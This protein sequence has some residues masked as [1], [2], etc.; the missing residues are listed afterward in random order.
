MRSIWLLALF[1]LRAYA[2]DTALS[3]SALH[4]EG[5]SKNNQAD[6]AISVA[7]EKSYY[8]IPTL[9]RICGPTNNALR[10]ISGLCHLL[11]FYNLGPTDIPQFNSGQTALRV[12]TDESTA[13]KIL[14]ASPFI[15]TRK[16]IRYV[17]AKD[18][19]FATGVGES[20]RDQCLATFA[21]LHLPLTTPL[22]LKAGNYSIA[23]LLSDS[24]AS[25]SFDEREPAWTGFALAKYL[26]PVR[27]WSNR[28]G[29][30]ASFSSL[31][32][33]LIDL[34]WN[35]QSCAGTHVFQALLAIQQ[36]DDAFGILDMSVRANLRGFIDNLLKEAKY[37]QEEDGGWP[38]SWCNK[39]HRNKGL[40]DSFE[41]RVIV[42]GHLLEVLD[43][44]P[45]AKR[46]PRNVYIK[47]A[48]ALL[49]ALNS[50][51]TNL[52]DSIICPFTHAARVARKILT[53]SQR[54][55]N[56]FP[57]H[58]VNEAGAESSIKH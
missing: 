22:T 37:S 41:Q 29:E 24:I 38:T 25:F 4:V 28:F 43:S 56:G 10:S 46:L 19:V 44:V 9:K 27:S 17:L 30:R 6:P 40:G 1:A 49:P 53:D 23:D 11:L 32:Q 45:A 15:R 47:G 55:I 12:L 18:P 26:P 8:E 51:A 13:V 7:T 33:H 31:A 16:G 3:P 54:D 57:P 42:T 58:R 35:T 48:Q 34:D 36:S 52:D 50:L 14:G 39:L 5:I 20:H 21:L 2:E